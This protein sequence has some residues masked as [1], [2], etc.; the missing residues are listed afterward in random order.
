MGFAFNTPGSFDKPSFLRANNSSETSN[1]KN[2]KYKRAVK[3]GKGC[4]QRS[5]TRKL[6]PRSKLLLRALGYKLRK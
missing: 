6:T 2:K 3:K 1:R 5:I 4:I